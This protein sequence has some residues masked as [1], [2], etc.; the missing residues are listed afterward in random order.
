[1]DSFSHK[2][3]GRGCTMTD[4]G[5]V[6]FTAHIPRESL[7]NQNF[8]TVAWTGDHLQLTV[9]CIPVCG[10]I[11]FELHPDTDQFIRVEQGQALVHMGKSRDH[12]TFQRL[13][14]VGE[15]VLVPC[16]TWHNVSNAGNRPLKLSSLYAPPQHPRGTVHPTKADGEHNEH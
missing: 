9:M 16:G 6:P 1:M 2:E 10:E 5:P 11:G 13:I 3:C 7:G 14:G 8:R 4:P 15:A 12:L